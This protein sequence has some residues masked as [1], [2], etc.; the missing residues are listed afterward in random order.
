VNQRSGGVQPPKYRRRI[1]TTRCGPPVAFI[2][3]KRIR[4]LF[5]CWK[6]KTRYSEDRYLVF[7]KT[8]QLQSTLDVATCKSAA[9]RL[10]KV[11]GFP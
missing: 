7:G 8:S 9:S 1:L 4:I 10:Q 6:T 5:R 11:A 3:G 2:R